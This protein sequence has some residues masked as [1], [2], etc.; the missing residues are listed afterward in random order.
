MSGLSFISYTDQPEEF[1]GHIK[2]AK[3]KG[4]PDPD[5]F[6]L[7]SRYRH[8]EIGA[9]FVDM[10]FCAVGKNG[11]EAVILAHKFNDFVGFNGSGAEI[12]IA[13]HTKKKTK[14][15][16][17][18]MVQSAR[19]E[20]CKVVKI[21]D[22]EVGFDLSVLGQEAFNHKAMPHTRLRAAQDLN[23]SEEA[24]FLDIRNSYRSLINKSKGEIS[25]T[26]VTHENADKDLFNNFM[27]FHKET[28][29]RQTRSTQSW[30]VQFEMI[31]AG[32]AELIMGYMEPHGLVS[33]ALFTDYGS[34]TSYAV[35]VYD[36]SLFE[37]PLAHANVYEGILCAKGRGQMIFNLGVIPPYNPD[38][39]KEYNIGKFKKGFCRTL[40][41]FIEWNIPVL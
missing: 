12:L 29:G 10:S 39:E 23:R 30:D 5:Q 21:D 1:L 3:I 25:F 19:R 40:S 9:G 20:N 15:I 17:G 4:L 37:K 33:S 14:S 24:V 13:E 32:H 18:F 27:A 28:A 2:G 38:H 22:Y 16:L 7:E 31:K 35:A 36:R 6:V 41:S 8:A 34:V 26:Y 11:L